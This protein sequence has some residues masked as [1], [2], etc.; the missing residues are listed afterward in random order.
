MFDAASYGRKNPDVVAAVEAGKLV[1]LHAHYV[2]TGWFEGRPL[3]R[4]PV[5][6]K[7][8]MDQYPDIARAKR[9]N[10]VRSAVEHYNNRGRLEGRAANPGELPA[11]AAWRTAL[12]R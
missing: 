11:I 8:Y 5:N 4:Y 3:G 2:F 7:W 6:E 9:E 12:G 1:S 10:V